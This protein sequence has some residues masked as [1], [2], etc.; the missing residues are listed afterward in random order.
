M[1]QSTHERMEFIIEG[2]VTL[3]STDYTLA[4][5]V[6]GFKLSTNSFMPSENT[7]ELR[8]AATGAKIEKAGNEAIY[9]LIE[10][11]ML[12]VPFEIGNEIEIPTLLGYFRDGDDGFNTGTAR[13]MQSDGD[14]RDFVL[15]GG[16]LDVAVDGN[17]TSPF[18]IEL[19]LNTPYAA[20]ISSSDLFTDDGDLSYAA[21]STVSADGLTHTFEVTVNSGSGPFNISIA[22]DALAGNLTGGEYEGVY[23]LAVPA[24]AVT[25]A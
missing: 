24:L 14:N 3:N 16:S 11:S 4:F 17:Q 8:N 2:T 15:I 18:D 22:A 12:K 25:L 23:S 7:I 10:P 1:A 13:V 20:A 21:N 5:V 19:T 9:G 6:S